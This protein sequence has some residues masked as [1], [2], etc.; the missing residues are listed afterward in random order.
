MKKNGHRRNLLAYLRQK[1]IPRYRELI[2]SWSSS[3]MTRKILILL[4][5]FW[6]FVKSCGKIVS[7]YKAS[8][9]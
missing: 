1:D 3:L 8:N 9:C 7:P 6:F 2:S 5:F 4:G